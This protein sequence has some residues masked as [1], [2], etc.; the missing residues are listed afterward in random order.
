MSL[1]N[2]WYTLIGKVVIAFIF[3]WFVYR[4]FINKK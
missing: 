4:F 2:I 3:L 1:E